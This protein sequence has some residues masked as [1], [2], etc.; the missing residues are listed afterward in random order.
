MKQRYLLSIFVFL[1]LVLLQPFSPVWASYLQTGSRVQ[2]FLDAAANGDIVTV[3][4]LL[5]TDPDLIRAE[6]RGFTAL[7][8]ASETGN[9]PMIELFLRKKADVGAVDSVLGYTPLHMAARKDR[10][11]AARLLLAAGA[12]INAKNTKG[13]TPLAIAARDGYKDL[14]ALLIEKGADV[15]IKAS[16]GS[17]PLHLAGLNGNKPLARLLLDNGADASAQTVTGMTPVDAALANDHVDVA[18]FILKHSQAQA[19][20][21]APADS[22]M[23]NHTIAFASAR[24]GNFDIYRMKMDGSSLEKLTS[25]PA[26]DG[27]PAWS[28]D[29]SKIAF[30][31]KREGNRDIYIM[32]AD[33]SNLRRLTD[34]PGEDKDPAW[35]PDGTM[36]AYHS[37]RNDKAD[38]YVVNADG[39]DAKRMTDG[40]ADDCSPNWSPDGGKIAFHSNRDGDL[41][42]YVMSADGS[43]PKRLTDS[44]G[45]DMSPVWSPDGGTIA[46]QSHR[47]GNY[48]I[49]LMHADGSSV[50]RLTD[51]PTNEARPSWSPDGQWLVYGVAGSG[52]Y[53]IYAIRTDGTRTVQISNEARLDAAPAWKPQAPPVAR[54]EKG[55]G[56]LQPASDSTV[57]TEHKPVAGEIGGEVTVT[58][59]L[60]G[61][62]TVKHNMTLM[63]F[64]NGKAGIKFG[65]GG[66]LLNPFRE[67]SSDDRFTLSVDTS[68]F[69]VD[70]FILTQVTGTDSGTWPLLQDGRGAVMVFKFA[71]CGYTID[72]GNVLAKQDQ[73]ALTNPDVLSKSPYYVGQETTDSG[74]CVILFADSQ[75]EPIP[76]KKLPTSLEKEET[77]PNVVIKLSPKRFKNVGK[78][79][80]FVEV[81]EGTLQYAT[82]TQLKQ[83]SQL[84]LNPD[85]I[86]LK[87]GMRI[88]I[89]EK[90]RLLGTEYDPLTE[91]VV[92]QDGSLQRATP[93]TPVAEDIRCDDTS[94]AEQR[95]SAIDREQ[96]FRSYLKAGAAHEVKED[97]EE[98]AKAYA[99]ALKC[100]PGDADVK[101]KIATCWHN[102]YLTQAIAAEREGD[103]DDAIRK[104]TEAISYKTVPSTQARLDSAR[105]TLQERAESER[106]R[107]E[108]AKWLRLAETAEKD[109]SPTTAMQLYK[110]AQAFAEMQDF[111]SLQAKI[112]ALEQQIIKKRAIEERAK[113]SVDYGSRKHRL[114]LSLKGRG[115]VH[116]VCFSPAGDKIASTDKGM[117]RIWD[118]S[119]STCLRL[120][121]GH[122]K[123]VGLVCFSGEG[124]LI[125]S[126]EPRDKVIKVWESS[127]GRCLRTIR[128]GHRKDLLDICFSPDGKLIISASDD[129]MLKLWDVNTGHNVRK[130][131]GHGAGIFSVDFAPDG[132]S[133]A[134]G[135]WDK[136]IKLWDVQSGELLKTLK[137][138]KSTIESL[139]F[140]PDGD[141]IAACEYWDNKVTVW[142]V[143]ASRTIVKED[144]TCA[145]CVAFSPSGDHV[146]VGDAYGQVHILNV[147]NGQWAKKFRSHKGFLG[148]VRINAVAFSPDGKH[149]VVGADNE[150]VKVFVFE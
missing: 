77:D 123:D 62:G 148:F 34:H 12:P 115:W 92:T 66:R 122:T 20:Q 149:V 18:N 26:I 30:H 95:D 69:D 52:K 90:L 29:G 109:G 127:T 128:T 58:G 119:T 146:A 27:A 17:A 105:K 57:T 108:Y 33:G 147:K 71:G 24:G 74:E 137:G 94:T 121:K 16:D 56:T 42:I 111:A 73:L 142:D 41:E 120:L 8:M 39:S 129:K 89:S 118:V 100:K 132:R 40:S 10:I 36:L 45:Q 55:S 134:S 43:A 1:S 3:K 60:V 64:K 49:Y 143:E 19:S 32:N 35:S 150:S 7:H 83:G 46:F 130:F 126:G 104:Y 97:W 93:D 51:E 136:T 110:E 135:S 21:P 91:L 53:G 96:D 112:D 22:W 37:Y 114:D 98:A 88:V 59:L 144:L 72:V 13:R 141:Y 75:K 82:G 44:P 81:L 5:D 79:D 78:D 65:E 9:K 11:S 140:S 28:P 103:L 84:H 68:Q 50:K 4:S 31:S 113:V 15:N 76:S 38:I 61:K 23:E 99:Q 47:N 107:Q 138:H 101:D 63:F 102:L 116:D 80:L 131:Q 70:E 106:R 125:A 67:P 117:I 87:P 145:V 14:A 86:A 124:N 54:P 2:R 6:Y 85:R 48:D 139:A 25:D 133:I